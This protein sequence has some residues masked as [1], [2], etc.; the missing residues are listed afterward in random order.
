MS[1]AG[2]ITVMIVW[3]GYAVST[4]QVESAE[5]ALSLLIIYGLFRLIGDYYVCYDGDGAAFWV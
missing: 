5:E 1:T 3:R 2:L 4:A